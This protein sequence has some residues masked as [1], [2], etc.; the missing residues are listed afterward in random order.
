MQV[1]PIA[2]KCIYEEREKGG[3]R[4]RGGEDERP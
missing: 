2:S 3:G 1:C 4:E